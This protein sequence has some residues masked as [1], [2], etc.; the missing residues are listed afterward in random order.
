MCLYACHVP[1]I[2]NL[3]TD[4][5]E[6]AAIR[7]T[8]TGKSRLD[9]PLPCYG[10]EKHPSASIVPFPRKNVD[11]SPPGNAKEYTPQRGD[12]EITDLLFPLVAGVPDS[13][14]DGCARGQH[15][16]QRLSSSS[17]SGHANTGSLTNFS[18]G[19]KRPPCAP[20]RHRAGGRP[21]RQ[22]CVKVMRQPFYLHKL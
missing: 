16:C 20:E 4:L 12:H 15:V 13:R 14:F 10:G 21:D 9:P 1:P 17:A 19:F 7:P 6:H 2:E 18:H 11:T 8:T 5:N 22:K 3:P